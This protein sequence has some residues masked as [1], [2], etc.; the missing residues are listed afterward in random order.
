M[1]RVL[2]SEKR[3]C[4]GC[5]RRDFLEIG[6]ASVAGI[7]LTNLLASS[8]ARAATAEARARNCIILF[9]YGSP[10]QLET[11]DMK[12]Q[13]PVEIRGEM[14]P[15]PSRLPGVPVC[16]YLPHT[17]QIMDR[18]TVI[19]SMSHPYPIHGVAYAMTGVPIIDV[20]MEL[21]PHDPRHQPY[22]WL[23]GRLPSPPAIPPQIR[24]VPCG[25]ALSLQFS[26]YGRG[27]SCG[28]LCRLFRQHLQSHLDGVSRPKRRVTWVKT[29]GS[30][31]L[32]VHD[33]YLGCTPDS[34]FQLSATSLPS[35]ITL[36]RLNRRH[37]LLQQFELERRRWEQTA[38]G[39]IVEPF[40]RIG[41]STVELAA[42]G[43]STRCALR[44][45]VGARAVWAHALW[46]SVP[47][48]TAIGGSRHTCGEC[49]L[50]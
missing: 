12:P 15:I 5:T 25:F 19:R 16:E 30:T 20:N 31:E 35:G 49:L 42:S 36:D 17:A 11:F 23:C 26:A 10:S 3:L 46:S 37:S 40:S 29:L 45:G 7:S 48:G 4:T 28:A 27:V 24:S 6:G 34:Y 38:A 8:A 41:I 39:Q 33:P 13:A 32:E 18:V 14:Q 9:L 44:A 47:S 50:G 21:S 22:F 1:W 43:S 2:G